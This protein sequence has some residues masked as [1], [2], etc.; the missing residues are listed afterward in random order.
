MGKTQHKKMKVQGGARESNIEAKPAK[1]RVGTGDQTGLYQHVQDNKQWNNE[2]QNYKSGLT[3]LVLMTRQ[4]GGVAS[5]SKIQNN[6]CEDSQTTY[7]DSYSHSI[8]FLD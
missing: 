8:P 5:K 4:V 6:K 2:S 7:S 3:F 1:P